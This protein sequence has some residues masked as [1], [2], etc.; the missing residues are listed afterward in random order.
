MGKQGAIESTMIRR[1]AIKRRRPRKRP[2]ED[3]KYQAFIR[4]LP[5]FICY[6]PLYKAGIIKECIEAGMQFHIID[7]STQ[8]SVTEFAHLGDRGLGQLCPDREGGPLCGEHHRTGPEAAHVLGRNF[9]L[10][11]GVDREEL[12]ALLLLLYRFQSGVE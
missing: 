2:G 12:F 6:W 9:F 7:S 10:Y 4:S 11:H 1:T 5:C 3:L 8:K